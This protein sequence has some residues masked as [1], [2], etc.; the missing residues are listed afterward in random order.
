[1][2]IR[3]RK[4]LLCAIL[5]VLLAAAALAAASE[6]KE[7]GVRLPV[8]MYHHISVKASALGK[9][10]VSP[11]QFRRDLEYIA[12]RGYTA[13]SAQQLLDFAEKGKALPDKPILI[14]FDDG[15]ESFY[16]YAYPI[17]KEL[18]MHAVLSIIGKYT[19]LYSTS[20]DH[21]VNYAHVTWDE[22]KQMSESGLVDIGH[23]TYDLHSLSSRRGCRIKKGESDSDYRKMLTAD[24]TGLQKKIKQATG[25][26]SPI[27]AYPFGSYCTQGCECVRQLGFKITLGCEERVNTIYPSDSDSL[28]MLNRFNR[29]SGKSSE[30]FFAE[31]S[32]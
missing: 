31:I 25:S 13:V 9:Y 18:K 12:A 22:V 21:N 6:P 17:L 10:V 23:H 32:E 20:D 28:Y 2:I 8:I 11:D 27:F 1:M 16:T 3:I 4:R 19:D 5:C 30:A 26:E 15:Y 7:G 24:L 14:T 29:A